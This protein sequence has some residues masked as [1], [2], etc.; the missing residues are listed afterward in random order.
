MEP[1]VI[2]IAFLA[3]VIIAKGVKAVPQGMEYTVE[4]FGRYTKTLHPG[5]IYVP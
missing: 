4:R 5:L 3:I 1:F 2:V